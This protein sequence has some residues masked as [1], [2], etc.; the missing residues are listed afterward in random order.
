MAGHN[1]KS[2][3]SIGQTG[4]TPLGKL[5]IAVSERGLAAIEDGMDQA[6]FSAYLQGRFKRTVELAPQR[7]RLAAAQL[8][9]YLA[10]RRRDFD[11]P[12]DWSLLTPFQ[13]AA[14][15]T[16]CAIPPGET[17]TYQ[18]IAYQIGRP[19]AARAVGRAEATNPLPLV[20]PCHRAVGTDGK[21]HGYGFG[22]GL[23]TKAWLLEMERKV[24]AKG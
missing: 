21:L 22:K 12:I 18:Q 9:E 4:E 20:I 1:L 6:R 19:R 8:E 11:L 7:V 15:R 10:G 24:K 5:W 3:L 17:R 14:L 23:E 13:Q 2:A 16:T